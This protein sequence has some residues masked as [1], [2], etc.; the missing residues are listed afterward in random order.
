MSYKLS[1]D[2]LN[3]D[4]FQDYFWS[5]TKMI[6]IVLTANIN[7]KMKYSQLIPTNIKW[8]RYVSDKTKA[9]LIAAASKIKNKKVI[10]P[11]EALRSIK[12]FVL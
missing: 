1:I 10:A 3:W 6:N 12:K 2:K 8:L 11:T 9:T 7:P 4:E 5:G